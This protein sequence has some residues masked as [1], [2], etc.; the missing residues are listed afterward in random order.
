MQGKPQQNAVVESAISRRMKGGHLTRREMRRP[1]P[2]VDLAR[3]LNIM[4]NGICPWLEA[5]L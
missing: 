4:P 5:V 1:F 3:I 2:G